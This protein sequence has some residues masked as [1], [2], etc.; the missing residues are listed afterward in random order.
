MSKG[1]DF[2]AAWFV[3]NFH[4]Q[5]ESNIIGGDR[6][7]YYL[8]QYGSGALSLCWSMMSYCLYLIV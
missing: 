5:M 4:V 1:S 8:S 2:G 6:W 7:I 3:A